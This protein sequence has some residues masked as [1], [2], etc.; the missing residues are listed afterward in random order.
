MI[1]DRLFGHLNGTDAAC[2]STD[3]PENGLRGVL[4]EAVRPSPGPIADERWAKTKA[5]VFGVQVWGSS[6]RPAT[7]WSQTAPEPS[8]LARASAVQPSPRS[9]GATAGFC[10]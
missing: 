3:S 10:I 4:C 5:Q 8:Q 9:C 7:L 2:L 1:Q 6:S